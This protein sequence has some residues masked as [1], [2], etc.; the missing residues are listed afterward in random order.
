LEGGYFDEL[1]SPEIIMPDDVCTNDCDL[2]MSDHEVQV[3]TPPSSSPSAERLSGGV[4]TAIRPMAASS[5]DR[6]QRGPTRSPRSIHDRPR[7]SRFRRW[8]ARL[9]RRDPS[10]P[11]AFKDKRPNGATSS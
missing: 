9:T 1:R 2:D 7:R 11:S 3:D 10:S 4:W 6:R 5:N 8:Q